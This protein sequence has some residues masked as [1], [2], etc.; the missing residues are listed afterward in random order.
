MANPEQLQ[1]WGV[2]WNAVKEVAGKKIDSVQFS[3][4]SE[5]AGCERVIVRC[6]DG[7]RLLLEAQPNGAI[8]AWLNCCGKPDGHAPEIV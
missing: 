8:R 3:A 6:Q 7:T 1:R 4:P 2:D 5:N